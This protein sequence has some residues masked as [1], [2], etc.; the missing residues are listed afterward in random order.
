VWVFVFVGFVVC[1]LC[2]VWC[3]FLL[4]WVVWLCGLCFVFV[5]L[6]FG[7]CLCLV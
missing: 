6:V 2:V 3:G 4:L 7:F 5:I 1:G